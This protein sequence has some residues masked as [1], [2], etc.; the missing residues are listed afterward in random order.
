D[1]LRPGDILG[2]LTGDAGIPGAMVGK[3]DIFDIQAYVAVDRDVASQAM[4]G[5]G[6]IKGRAFKVRKV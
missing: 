6:K 1:K 4:K 3:I 2:A 5:L